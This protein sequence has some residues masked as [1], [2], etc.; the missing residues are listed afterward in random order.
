MSH[1]VD[2][3][4]YCGEICNDRDGGGRDVI[5]WRLWNQIHSIAL[6]EQ[7]LWIQRCGLVDMVEDNIGSSDAV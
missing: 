6:V 3:T 4:R 1:L 2:Q 5:L 7:V